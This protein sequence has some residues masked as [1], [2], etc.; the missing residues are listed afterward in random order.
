LQRGEPPTFD[1]KGVNT[2]VTVYFEAADVHS[3]LIVCGNVINYKNIKTQ[4]L[5]QKVL[6]LLRVCYAFDRN[7]PALYVILLVI[8]RYCLCTIGGAKGGQNNVTN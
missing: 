3:I 2:S 4:T 7:Y 8:E 5:R 6:Y 1:Y